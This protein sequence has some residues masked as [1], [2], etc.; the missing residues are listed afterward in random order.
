MTSRMRH[1]RLYD[2]VV[3]S[4]LDLHLAEV[5][6][7]RPV[8]LAIHRRVD[9]LDIDWEA[10]TPDLLV[11]FHDEAQQTGY[12]AARTPDGYRLRFTG[13]CE[14]DL[15]TDLA[16]ATW[17]LVP[18]RAPDLVSVLAVGALSAF[19]MVMAGRLVL[20]ASAVCARRRGLA[21]VGASGMGKST[22][23]TLMCSGGAT[24]LT[25]DVAPVDMDGREVLLTPGGP[26]SRLRPAASV[27]RE[28]FDV[29]RTTSDGRTAVTLPSWS[30]GPVTLDAVVIPLPSR[31]RAEVVLAPLTPADALIVL[32]QF[33]RLPGW[34]DIEVL[35]QQ[36]DL[37]A[38]L[39]DRVPVY[40]AQVPWGPPF[41]GDVG[42]QLLEALGWTR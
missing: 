34:V 39:V 5:E 40:M 33:P 23:A 29:A 14:F 7:S 10:T 42:D 1:Y 12:V 21:F 41:V 27:L 38:D 31:E 9:P 37:L 16:E 13:L 15:S 18:G 20:H 22:M 30:D 17:A 4:D 3:S 11:Q 28:R 19:R 8:E 32:S 26:E 24:L 35:R 2:W 25:D 36:F 6:P